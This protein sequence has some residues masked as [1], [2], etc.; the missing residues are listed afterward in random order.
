[1][2]AT[3]KTGVRVVSVI[4]LLGAGAALAVPLTNTRAPFQ[5]DLPAGWGQ[6]DYPNNLPGIVVVAPGSPPPVVLQMF[7][8]PYKSSG[9]DA[10]ALSEFIGGV[11]SGA[12]GNGQATLKRISERPLTVGG[13]KGTE[14]IY[15]L[16]VKANGAVVQARAWYGVGP[17]NLFQFQ[18]VTGVKATPAQVAVFDRLL[19]TVKFR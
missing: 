4:A 18:S 14:H 2:S 5:A 19:S 16:M 8:A 17:K 15:S 3:L 1:M 6:R 11:E 10:R 12:T 7:Y 13:I 9:N